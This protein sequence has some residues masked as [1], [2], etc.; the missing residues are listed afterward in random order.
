MRQFA[1]NKPHVRRRLVFST[2]AVLA[3]LLGAWGWRVGRL[4]LSLR[5]RVIRL[6][7]SA[8][9]PGQ[10]RL[11]ELAREVHG[12]RQEMT[13][14]RG[15]LM[16]VLWL[17]E[18]LGGDLS[19]GRPLMDAAV[20]A[21]TAGDEALATLAPTFNDLSPASIS[22]SALPRVLDGLATARPALQSAATHLDAASARLAEAKGPF[23]SRVESW[24]ARA[25]NYLAL[26]RQG[27]GAALVAPELLG[28]DGAHTYLVLMQ[29]SDELRP[30]GGFISTVGRAMISH[31]AVITQTFEDS[32]GIDD[33]TKPY[34]DPPQPLLDYMGS[35]LWVFRDANWSPDFPTAARDA[36]AL[37]QISRLEK[38]DSVIGINLKMV[39][40][41]VAGLEPLQVEGLPEPLTSA[42][43][44]QLFRQAWDP[45]PGESTAL[46]FSGRKSFVGSTVQAIIDKL[47]SG[48]VNWVQLGRETLG[49]LNQ[50]QLTIYSIGPEAAEL[51]RLQWDG[52]VRHDG[53]DYLMVVDAN[54]G[55]GKVNPLI[56][57]IV[58]YRVQL[59]PDGTGRAEVTLDY[60][61]RGTQSGVVCTPFPSY[62]GVTYERLLNRCYHNYLRVMIP[63]GGRLKS[64]IPHPVPGAYLVTGK[65]SE[66]RAQ[67]V[68]D[69]AGRSVV[70]QFFVVEYGQRLQARFEYN[71]PVV[72]TSEGGHWR[73]TLVLQKQSGTDAL[74]VKVRLTLPP[75][76]HWLP[77]RISPRPT[78]QSGTSLEFDV[79]LDVDRQVQVDFAPAAR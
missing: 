11:A 52:A 35:E 56:E 20:D 3:L 7:K 51:A 41:L 32:Y 13:A 19:A 70:A 4:T 47:Q 77:G 61:H 53:T 73:Y 75:G 68:P 9:D 59:Q 17:G 34:P 57:R 1:D 18:R 63:Q 14:L 60:A 15:E 33:F 8:A 69:E 76:A 16:P 72:V 49:M 12:A 54:V 42:N 21:V 44:E 24:M 27:I 36:I 43:V 55:Y 40:M 23:S 10:V 58:D 71:L 64:A 45:Q 22:V 28:Q 2:L 62:E 46:W 39:R 50:R 48:R 30:T 31:G 66:G 67:M 37:Y 78:L 74:P 29:N 25:A 65:P 5:D 26:A 6:Q 79:S 38:I